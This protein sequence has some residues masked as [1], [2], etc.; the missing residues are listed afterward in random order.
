M[1]P[2]T[3][4]VSMA[5]GRHPAVGKNRIYEAISG[6]ALPAIKV[7]RRLAI[8]VHEFDAWVEAGCPTQCDRTELS[9]GADG[10]TS[11]P[12]RQATPP[13]LDGEKVTAEEKMEY[14]NENQ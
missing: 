8:D 9:R 3:M 4:T 10:S 6:Q 1:E 5:R 12:Q 11:G 7:G 13:S 2:K 14:K